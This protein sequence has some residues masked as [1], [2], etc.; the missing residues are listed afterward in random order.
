MRKTVEAH[1]SAKNNHFIKFSWII[2][3]VNIP[4]SKDLLNAE[5]N[6][7]RHFCDIWFFHNWIDP[8]TQIVV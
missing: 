8:A 3:E 7:T 4:I 6:H 5:I 2:I 1:L